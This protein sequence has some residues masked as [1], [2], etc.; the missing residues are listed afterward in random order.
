MAT[1]LKDSLRRFKG[2]IK[3]AIAV[4][5]VS[6]SYFTTSTSY[7]YMKLKIYTTRVE[8]QII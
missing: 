4:L 8:F 3:K 1:D 2:F 7:F 5:Y 6:R